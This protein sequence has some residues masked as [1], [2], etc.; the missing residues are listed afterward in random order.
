MARIAPQESALR[1][2]KAKVPSLCLSTFPE[3]LSAKAN[4]DQGTSSSLPNALAKFEISQ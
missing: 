1:R 4:T 3:L 2:M